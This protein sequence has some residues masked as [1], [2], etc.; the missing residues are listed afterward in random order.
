[1]I[2][3]AAINAF[4]KEVQIS[5]PGQQQQQKYQQCDFGIWIG[6]RLIHPNASPVQ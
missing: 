2:G 3:A 1:V 4:E 5:Y 6:S